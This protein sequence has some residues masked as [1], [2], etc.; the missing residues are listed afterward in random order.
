MTAEVVVEETI[1]PIEI[2]R[3]GLNV[4][5]PGSELW[6]WVDAFVVLDVVLTM[7]ADPSNIDEIGGDEDLLG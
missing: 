6:S 1:D 5:P 4:I 2:G 7:A 3:L